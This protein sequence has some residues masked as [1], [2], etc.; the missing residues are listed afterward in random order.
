MEEEIGFTSNCLICNKQRGIILPPGGAIY[1]DELVYASHSFIPQ[2]ESNVYLG[3]LFLEP[4]R[5]ITGLEELTDAE[6]RRIGE[7]I[8]RLSKALKVSTGAE[9]IYLFVLGHHVDH[10][11]FWLIPRYLGTPR[12]YWG[13]RVDEWPDAPR[14]GEFEIKILCDRIRSLLI[15]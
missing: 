10:L 12:E 14:G 4:K 5:H 13:F 15:I 3:L 8:T 2:D 7:L 6:S 1:E 9:H 11:H